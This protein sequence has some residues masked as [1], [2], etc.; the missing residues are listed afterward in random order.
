M[1]QRASL[2][3]A[4]AGGLAF[5]AFFSAA[6]LHAGDRPVSRAGP[7]VYHPPTPKAE[8][9]ASDLVIAAPRLPLAAKHALGPLPAAEK[10]ALAAGADNRDTRLRAKKPAV[11]VG[12]SRDLPEAVGFAS[13]PAPTTGGAVVGG[14]LFEYAGGESVWTASFTSA[15]AGALRLHLRRAQLPPGSRAYVYSAAGEVHGPYTFERELPPEGFW[16]NTV[17]AD[18]IFLEVHV[19]AGAHDAALSVDEVVHL[20][21]PGFAPSSSSSAARSDA[22]TARPKSDSCFIDLSCVAPS[23]FPSVDEASDAIGQLTFMDQGGAFVCSGGLMNASPA[24]FVPY[25][26]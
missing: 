6:A 5:L 24:T 3:A 16:T 22:A 25:L 1:R 26:L 7:A 10:S 14:G 11:R 8:A 21:H 2:G 15:G 20:E 4:L 19:P 18:E 12:L 13:L 9:A 23:N 17:F